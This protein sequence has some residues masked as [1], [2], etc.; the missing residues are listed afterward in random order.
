MSGVLLEEPSN[1]DEFGRGLRRLLEDRPYAER[2]GAAARE[3]ARHEF[4]GLRH[5]VEYARL[6]ERLDG[7]DPPAS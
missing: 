1:L 6:I 7:E 4:L 5:L 2:L 3:R